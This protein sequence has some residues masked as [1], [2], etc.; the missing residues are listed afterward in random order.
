MRTQAEVM[1]PQAIIR[2]R[3]TFFDESVPAKEPGSFR[4]R[5][6]SRK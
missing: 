2:D 5:A 4:E 3:D 6:L 1:L